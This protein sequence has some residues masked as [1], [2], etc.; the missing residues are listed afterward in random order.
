MTE[1]NYDY[2]T[3]IIRLLYNKLTILAQ[4]AHDYCVV[5]LVIVSQ[6]T[7]YNNKRCCHNGV[8]FLSNLLNQKQKLIYRKR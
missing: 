6:V 2:C 3:I 5:F 7:S 4:L 8:K 1:Y